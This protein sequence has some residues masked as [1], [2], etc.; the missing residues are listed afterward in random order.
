MKNT[1]QLILT[2]IFTSILTSALCSGIFLFTVSHAAPS[3]TVAQVPQTQNS[4][5]MSG[6]YDES[7][8]VST[9]A[10]SEPA[11]ASVIITKNLPVIERYNSN[12]GDNSGNPFDQFFNFQIPQYRQNGTQQQE[13]GGGTAFFVTKDGLLMT[14]KHVVDDTQADYTV[15]LNDGRKLPAKV[16]ALDPG[17]DIALLKVNGN[18]FT[19]LS[20][21]TSNPKLGQTT[22][23]IGNALGE[24]RNTVSVGVVS[25]LSRSIDAGSMSDSQ[26]EHI[27]NII[28]TDAA[29][30]PG[31]SGGPLLNAIG[32]VLGMNTAV[33][34]SAQ[35]IG[36][37][38]RAQDLARAL[39]LYEKNGKITRPYLGIRYLLVNADLQKQNK[40]PYD[41]GALVVRGENP[42]DLAVIPG[43]PADKAE[44]QENDIILSIDGQKIDENMSLTS[45]V[46][47]HSPGDVVTL[48]IYQKG[49]EKDVKVT[50][51]EQK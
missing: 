51:E 28:Q 14:N 22:I 9:V 4:T 44:L 10:K 38:I 7:V 29:I 12:F 37:A 43:S 30:N 26:G 47:N 5:S 31:N 27:D 2:V 35:N 8:I 50:L 41:Y 34:Q 19:P 42:T 1:R 25:G 13:V 21:A 6:R 49:K 23:A 32:E 15:L 20:F 40:L 48:H 17:N 24:F 33:S 11:V 16:V 18:G 3:P 36:F 45:I 39:S 46:G